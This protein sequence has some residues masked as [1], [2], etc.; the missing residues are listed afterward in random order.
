MKFIKKIKLNIKS[1]RVKLLIIVAIIVIVEAIVG[2]TIINLQRP[3]QNIVSSQESM[4][5]PDGVA[6]SATSFFLT[7][8]LVRIFE[9]VI[10]LFAITIIFDRMVLK[11]LSLLVEYFALVAGGDLTHKIDLGKKKKDSYDEID[12]IVSSYDIFIN[13]ITS[14]LREIK[15]ASI[16]FLDASAS[17][18]AE[19]ETLANGAHAQVGS[20]E[21]LTAS[22]ETIAVGARDANEKAQLTAED[23][24]RTGHDMN[25]LL[26]S[27][28]AIEDSFNQ[29]EESIS[30]INDI[31]DQTNLLALN[32][33][34]EA[35][36]AG[37][38]G[39]G[40]AVVAD[41]VRKLAERSASQAKE[42][43]AL[44]NQNRLEVKKGRDLSKTAEESLKLIVYNI[45][46]VADEFK[47]VFQSIA[48][49]KNAMNENSG[50]TESNAATSEELSASAAGMSSQAT[51]LKMLIDQFKL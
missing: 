7:L 12:E 48:V 41:E 4:S 38:H 45:N 18:S 46:C 35:A 5:E 29:I 32:A 22:A 8:V 23:A 33:A 28:L 3:Q 1:L 40:F 11:R 43:E 31:A 25:N 49:Q 36:R 16:K 44:V 20:F 2:T 27:V 14:V 51:L 15:K 19:S 10:L 37:E 50:V 17:I 30:F 6:D 47:T 39:K 13:Q 34:I 24:E 42:I 26:Q 21:E 9:G